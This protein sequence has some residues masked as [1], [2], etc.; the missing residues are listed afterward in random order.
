MDIFSV[1]CV[2]VEMFADGRLIPFNLS[3]AIDYKRMDEHS[4]RHYIRRIISDIPPE[5]HELLTIMLDRN[6]VRRREEFFKV[7]LILFIQ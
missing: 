3:Q 4:A 7:V 5:F 1:G 2:L 6:P